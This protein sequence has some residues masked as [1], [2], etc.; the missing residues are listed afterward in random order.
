MYFMQCTCNRNVL[1]RPWPYQFYVSNCFRS[2]TALQSCRNIKM[3][4]LQRYLEWR[5][6]SSGPPSESSEDV[7]N[8]CAPWLLRRDTDN[9]T[10]SQRREIP[11]C[12]AFQSNSP[13]FLC[14]VCKKCI[15]YTLFMARSWQLVCPQISKANWTNF[16][17]MLEIYTRNC[18]VNTPLVHTDWVRLLQYYLSSK[19]GVT[20]LFQSWGHI[21]NSLTNRE[22]QS[23][24][25]SLMT[26]RYKCH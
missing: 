23:F 12:V 14:F 16:N 4:T 26:V 2:R 17:S 15:K 9:R 13:K 21:Y 7:S 5:S 22:P 24:E 10:N 6:S 25:D 8:S 19:T 11:K 3:E 1:R 18:P 20:N